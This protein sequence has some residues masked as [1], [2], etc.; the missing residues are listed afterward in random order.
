MRQR[1]VYFKRRVNVFVYAAD[2]GIVIWI[3]VIVDGY[4]SVY[5]AGYYGSGFPAA[6]HNGFPGFVLKTLKDC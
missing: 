2:Y 3:A 6:D 1:L 4:N 5:V